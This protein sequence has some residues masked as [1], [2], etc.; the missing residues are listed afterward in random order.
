MRKTNWCSCLHETIDAARNRAFNYGTFDCALFA[1]DC[2]K[3][4]TGTDYA[5]SLRGY[6]SKM[7]AYRI[8]ASYGSLQ[9]MITSLLQREPIAVQFAQPGDVVLASADL[10]PG[11]SGEVIGIC[12]GTRFAAPEFT[13]ISMRPMKLAIAAWRID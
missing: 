2:V 9:S 7:D 6:Q 10:G 5:E 4:M 12:L 3:A 11:E 13:G 8:V 1:A